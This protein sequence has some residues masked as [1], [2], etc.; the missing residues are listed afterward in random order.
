MEAEGVIVEDTWCK[1]R[2][3]VHHDL[4]RAT[5]SF[6]VCFFTMFEMFLWPR[7]EALKNLDAP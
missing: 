3:K 2:H 6:D 4:F 7:K 5:I 1:I